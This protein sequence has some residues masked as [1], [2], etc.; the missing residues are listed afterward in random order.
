MSVVGSDMG[1]VMDRFSLTG[2]RALVTGASRGLG[3]AMAEALGEAGADVVCASSRPDGAADTAAALR[4]MGRQ[5]W[6]VDADL[7]SRDAT[8]AMAEAAER[9]AGQIDI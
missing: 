1:N 7:G 9:A 4:A 3:R 2:K 8:L 6:T 5:A